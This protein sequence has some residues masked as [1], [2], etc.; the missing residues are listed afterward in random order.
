MATQNVASET[1]D[2]PR[3]EVE[4]LIQ[5]ALGRDWLKSGMGTLSPEQLDDA[6]SLCADNAEVFVR[7][8]GALG[9]V[10]GNMDTTTLEDRDVRSIG[11]T[12][13]H[14]AEFAE[15]CQLMATMAEQLKTPKG[16]AWHLEGMIETP[17]GKV[18]VRRK[19]NAS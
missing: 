7:Q 11:W 19:R 4:R 3:S 1:N 10:L 13:S 14:L 12:I 9:R 17:E 2:V 16:R 18:Q 5:T 15:C 6:N 8:I